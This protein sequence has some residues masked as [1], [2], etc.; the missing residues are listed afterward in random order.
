M[1]RSPR[2]RRGLLDS[3]APGAIAAR[4]R[5][6]ARPSYL[7]D[8]VLGAVDGTITTFAIVASAAGAGLSAG[9]AL[10]VGLANVLAD[11]FSMAAGNALRARADLEILDQ[12][13]AMEEHHVATVPE[14]EREEVRQIFAAK[15]FDGEAL[16]Q[17]VSIVT[18]DRRRW[19]DTML[20]EEHG[21]RLNPPQPWTTAWVTFVAFVAAGL[22]P[23]LPLVAVRVF[24]GAGRDAF[25]ASAV[26]TAVTFFL[27]GWLKG[28]VLERAPLRQGLET[29]G[30]GALAASLAWL[31]GRLIGGLAG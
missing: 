26:A 4:L 8:A 5:D 24:L 11:G 3:H 29:L 30:V 13:R 18:G 6:G 9:V 31:V 19:I 25:L 14:G 15:G 20:R 27:V 21:L 1:T 23:L 10:V 12:T 7:G 17:A 16:E 2:T 22:V 28:R